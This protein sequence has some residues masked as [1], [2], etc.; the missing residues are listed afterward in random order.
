M[1]DWSRGYWVIGIWE[2]GVDLCD[3]CDREATTAAVRTRPEV[4]LALLC[5]EHAALAEIRMEPGG[6]T[7]TE[8]LRQPSGEVADC[9]AVAT[10]VRLIGFF[11]EDGEEN[12]GFE[13]RCRRHA[14]VDD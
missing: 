8:K 2:I 12:N 3:F 14:G 7:C 11:E 1:P 13:A 6:A 10:H 4:G 5:D 9:G